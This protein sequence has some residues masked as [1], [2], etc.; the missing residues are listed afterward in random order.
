[1]LTSLETDQKKSLSSSLVLSTAVEN[2]SAIVE[3]VS[4]APATILLNSQLLLFS[5]FIGVGC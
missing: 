5:G 4:F 3:A 2:L 1:M